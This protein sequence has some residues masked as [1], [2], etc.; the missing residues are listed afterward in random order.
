VD[1]IGGGGASEDIA[2]VLY[3]DLINELLFGYRNIFL[4]KYNIDANIYLYA[5][6]I[7]ILVFA[8]STHTHTCAPCVGEQLRE[9]N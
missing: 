9:T 6:H 1:G 7:L 5:A 3:L 4:L 2:L 8:G